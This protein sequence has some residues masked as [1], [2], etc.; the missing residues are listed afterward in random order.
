MSV[1]SFA[2]GNAPHLPIRIVLRSLDEGPHVIAEASGSSVAR[3]S[4]EAPDAQGHP[5]HDPNRRCGGGDIGSE[6]A[7]TSA[8]PALYPGTWLRARITAKLQCLLQS[9]AGAR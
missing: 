6:L 7:R 4:E 8:V 2:C 1:R 3:P 9:R 5:D